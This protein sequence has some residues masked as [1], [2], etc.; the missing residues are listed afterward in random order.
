MG[1]GDLS[2]AAG[3][4]ETLTERHDVREAWFSLAAARR[5]LRDVSGAVAALGAA[6]SRHVLPPPAHIAPLA[7][8]VV[9]ESGMPGW[10]GLMR[11]GR[12]VARCPEGTRVQLLVD[13]A[14]LPLH[15]QVPASATR[16][17]VATDRPLLGSPILARL[18]RRI[19]GVVGVRDGGI[20]GWAWH[21]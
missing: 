18:A 6:L 7:D 10:C 19:E 21:P 4:L 12:I 14:R 16:V 5:G 13:R 9:A 2:S 17:E 1:L 15:S 11:T 20:E 8:A 3:L